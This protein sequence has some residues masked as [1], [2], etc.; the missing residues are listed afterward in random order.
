M[1]SAAKA[2]LGKENGVALGE[3]DEDTRPKAEA[4]FYSYYQLHIEPDPNAQGPAIFH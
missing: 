1:S 2:K 4:R 3:L